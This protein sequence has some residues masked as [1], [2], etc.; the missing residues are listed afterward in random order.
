MGSPKGFSTIGTSTPETAERRVQLLVE[1]RYREAVGE[2]E[3][4]LRRRGL[5]HQTVRGEVEPDLEAARIAAVQEARRQSVH[6][7]S[8]GQPGETAT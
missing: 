1:R 7:G 2:R 8:S 3:R 4:L 6:A 5:D